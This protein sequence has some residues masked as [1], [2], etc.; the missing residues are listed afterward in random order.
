MAINHFARG[1]LFSFRLIICA[2]E[3]TAYMHGHEQREGGAVSKKGCLHS[4]PGRK[5]VGC[6]NEPVDSFDNRVRFGLVFFFFGDVIYLGIF[7]SQMVNIV[8][9]SPKSR[10]P[11]NLLQNST[12]GFA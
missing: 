11:K 8:I 12:H 9:F 3:L 4:F 5:R 2:I 6:H 1:L 10:H 7:C